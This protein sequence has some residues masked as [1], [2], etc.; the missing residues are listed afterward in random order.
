MASMVIFRPEKKRPKPQDGCGSAMA[1]RSAG[2]LRPVQEIV[3]NSVDARKE[4]LRVLTP[5]VKKKRPR[6][7]PIPG[8]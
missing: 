6:S 3:G 1:Y 8:N 4:I 5:K 2:L 7:G